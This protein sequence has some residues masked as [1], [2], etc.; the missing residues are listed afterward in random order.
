MWD[1]SK[2]GGGLDIYSKEVIKGD[3]DADVSNEMAAL[4]V[5]LEEQE[6]KSSVVF[7]VNRGKDGG[8]K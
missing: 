6:S 5:L 3:S 1:E 7:C 4:P 8:D 2:D